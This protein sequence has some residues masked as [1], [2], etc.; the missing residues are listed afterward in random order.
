MTGILSNPDDLALWR[1]GIIAPLVAVN[2]L[3]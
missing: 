1:F 2:K 3:T